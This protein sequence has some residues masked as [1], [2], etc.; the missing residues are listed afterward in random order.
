MLD[1]V[2]LVKTMEGEFVVKVKNNQFTNIKNG[3]R[4][5]GNFFDTDSLILNFIPSNGPN[6]FLYRGKKN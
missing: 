5:Y 2:M 1:S 3:Q 4:F 6:A